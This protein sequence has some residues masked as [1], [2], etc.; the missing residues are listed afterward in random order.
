M[1]LLVWQGYLGPLFRSR[2]QPFPSLFFLQT[3]PQTAEQP[4]EESAANWRSA[5]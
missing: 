2:S 4:A 5:R 1:Q 3:L